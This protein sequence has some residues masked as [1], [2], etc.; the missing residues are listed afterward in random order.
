MKENKDVRMR[1]RDG[2]IIGVV[3]GAVAAIIFL[4][5]SS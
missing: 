2:L 5:M 1:F 3:S 4:L